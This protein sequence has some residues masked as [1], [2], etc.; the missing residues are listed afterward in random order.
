[1]KGGNRKLI[2]TRQVMTSTEKVHVLMIEDDPDM[3][4]LI[5]AYLASIRRFSFSI[6]HADT[7]AQGLQLLVAGKFEENCYHIVLLDL[8]L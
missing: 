6:V 1:M 7:L 2:E 5:Q 3:A 8:F 4:E